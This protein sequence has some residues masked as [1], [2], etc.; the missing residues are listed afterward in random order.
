MDTRVLAGMGVC[1]P[2]GVAQEASKSRLRGCV[3]HSTETTLHRNVND[4]G[5]LF[6]IP[7]HQTRTGRPEDCSRAG[8]GRPPK[9]GRG[10]LDK[11]ASCRALCFV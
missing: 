10:V 4:V 6:Q 7:K 8:H 1:L 9:G 5:L 2:P 11:W 3:C